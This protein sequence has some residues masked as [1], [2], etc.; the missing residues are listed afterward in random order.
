MADDRFAQQD[1]SDG[2][3]GL[4]QASAERLLRVLT[5]A[6]GRRDEALAVVNGFFGDRLADQGSTLAI[7]MTVRSGTEV[8]SIDRDSL[9]R[10]LPQATGR[11]A[12][13]VHGLMSTESVWDFPGDPD[14]TYG[15][16]L[17]RDHGITP[18]SLRYNTGRHIS[19]NGREFARLLHY[20]VAA[21][22]VPVSDITLIGHSMGGLVIR[23]ACHYAFTTRPWHGFAR[24]RR[25]WTSKTRRV[26]LIGVPNTGAP[27]EVFVSLT[28]AALWS[29]PIPATHLVGLGLDARSAGIKDLKFG[30]ITDED[31][32]DQDLDARDGPVAHHVAMLKRA[33]YL[34]IAG[35]LTADPAHPLAR[36][37]GDALVTASSASGI[38]SEMTGEGLFPGSTVRQLP[39]VTHMALAHRSQVYDEID[40]WWP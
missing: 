21:W 24:F 9:A 10:A 25:S 35:G 19:V 5:A 7:P 37:F 36:V 22:P 29:L 38:L 33:A 26:V 11:I 6:P 18:V 40:R 2:E 3:R 32:L 16:L 39:R 31:W 15:S 23:S 4:I 27:L 12:L 8:L 30:A 20:L 13:L 28:S 1:T 14:T 34:I 17:A